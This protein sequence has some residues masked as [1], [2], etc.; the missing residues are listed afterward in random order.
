ME[1]TILDAVKAIPEH[2]GIKLV[3]PYYDPQQPYTGAYFELIGSDDNQPDR[4]TAVDLYAVSMLAVQVPAKAGIGILLEQAELFESLLSRVPDVHIKDL[5]REEFQRDLG[6]DSVALELWDRLR[7]NGADEK[8]WN[9]GPTTASKIMARKRPHLIPIEDS[10][11]D[12]VTQRGKRD[13]W[14]MWWQAFHDGGDYLEARADQIRAAVD[15]PDLSTLRV[16][17]VMLWSWGKEQGY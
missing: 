2:D 1:Q 5:S 16:F 3:E 8:R 13:S 7:R 14:K 9:V 17:D 10:V 4:F 15:R 12:R 6:P 11:V